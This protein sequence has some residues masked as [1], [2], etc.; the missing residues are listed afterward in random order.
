[1]LMEMSPREPAGAGGETERAATWGHVTPGWLFGMDASSRE[2]RFRGKGF[3]VCAGFN[4]VLQRALLGG[5]S[6]FRGRGTEA[7]QGGEGWTAPL[8]WGPACRCSML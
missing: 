5:A 7:V 2:L 1:M 4:C 8:P 6:I 3:L